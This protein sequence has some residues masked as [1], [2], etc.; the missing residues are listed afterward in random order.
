MQLLGISM[1]R[2][3]KKQINV[4]N[5]NE[6]F[7][8]LPRVYIFLALKGLNHCRDITVLLERRLRNSFFFL[9]NKK[10]T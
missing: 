8:E 9:L 10:L 6:A 4:S 7:S 2:L 3:T 1:M 5:G